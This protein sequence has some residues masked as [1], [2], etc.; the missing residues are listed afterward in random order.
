MELKSK[1]LFII[2][3]LMELRFGNLWLLETSPLVNTG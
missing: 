3:A 2:A 1:Q